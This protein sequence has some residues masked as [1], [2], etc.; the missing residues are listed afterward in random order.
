M[1]IACSGRVCSRRYPLVQGS[2]ETVLSLSG[3]CGPMSIS[4][5][6]A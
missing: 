6:L 4:D 3:S 5:E 2:L 1:A